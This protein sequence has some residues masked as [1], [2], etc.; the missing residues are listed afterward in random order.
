M[1]FT[2]LE[3]PVN[4]IR[5]MRAAYFA[6]FTETRGKYWLKLFFVDVINISGTKKVNYIVVCQSIRN[7]D[8][9]V[10][11]IKMCKW[12]FLDSV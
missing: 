8:V 9:F 10:D 4:F 6:C 2:S 1:L 12:F 7:G 5:N 3:C 11:F